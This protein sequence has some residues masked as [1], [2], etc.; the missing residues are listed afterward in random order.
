MRHLLLSLLI[1]APVGITST[2]VVQ[3]N[4]PT[5]RLTTDSYM[6]AYPRWLPWTSPI[7]TMSVYPNP[8]NPEV[9]PDASVI[10]MALDSKGNAHIVYLRPEVGEQ[11]WP[12]WYQNTI[13]QTRQA[14]GFS[15][16][17]QITPTQTGGNQ[18]CVAVAGN[19]DVYVAWS[20]GSTIYYRR[21]DANGWG[22]PTDLDPSIPPGTSYGGPKMKTAPDGTVHL[23]AFRG[24]TV[25]YEG[26]QK[27]VRD[28]VHAVPGVSFSTLTQASFNPNPPGYYPEYFKFAFGPG[29]QLVLVWMEV[30]TDLGMPPNWNPAITYYATDWGGKVPMPNPPDVEPDLAVDSLGNCHMAWRLTTSAEWMYKSTVSDVPVAIAGTGN[31]AFF[32]RGG[33]VV[34]SRDQV[35]LVYS[36]E[37]QG[38]FS[39]SRLKNPDPQVLNTVWRTQHL[40]LPADAKRRQNTVTAPEPVW[41][42]LSPN[43]DGDV[44]M[45]KNDQLHIR[46]GKLYT[47]T[48][49]YGTGVQDG[50]TLVGACPGGT[51]NAA[52]GNLNIRIPLF[53][54]KGVGPTQNLELRYNSLDPSVGSIAP[55]WKF[56]YEMYLI[57]PFRYVNKPGAPKGYAGVPEYPAEA[58]T[59]FMP[60]GRP[61]VFRFH[62]FYLTDNSWGLLLP[63]DEFGDFSSLSR[64]VYNSMTTEYTLTT[65]FGDKYVFNTAGKLRSILD[66]DQNRIDLIYNASGQLTQIIDMLGNGGVGRT[67]TITYEPQT[68]QV[69]PPRP[70]LITDPAAK[71]YE[72]QYT[73]NFLTGVRFLGHATQPT[74]TMQYSLDNNVVTKERVNQLRE[75]RT[76]RGNAW[77]CKYLP[78]GRVCEIEDPPAPYLLEG[79]ADGSVPG[80]HVAKIA[81]TYDETLPIPGPRETMLVDR[82]GFQTKYKIDGRRFLA[83]EIHDQAYLSG[84]PGIFPVI[85][86]F[87]NVGNVTDLQDR[88]G[89]HTLY[90]YSNDSG[91]THKDNLLTVRRPLP[92]GS[93][94][95]LVAEYTY[96]A[97]YNRPLT[98]TTYATPA[99]GGPVQTRTTTYTHEFGRLLSIF[100]PSV[101]RPDG[102]VQAANTQFTYNS[103][104]RY[105]MVIHRNEELWTTTFSNLDPVHGLPR[106]V[107][108]DGGTQTQEITYDAMGN[109]LQHK[110]PQGGSGNDLPGWTIINRD[111]LYR[112]SSVTD[113]KGKITTYD[114]DLDSN[115][116]FVIPPVGNQTSYTYDARGFASGGTGPDGTWAQWVDAAGNLRRSRDLRGFESNSTL[117]FM[118]RTTESRVPGGTTT[119]GGGGGPTSHV[120]QYAYDQLDTER[121]STVTQVGIPQNRVTRTTYDNRGRAKSILEPDGLTRTDIIFDEQDQ[122]I[123]SQQFYNSVF[124]RCTVTFRDA[125]DR[126]DRT[127]DQDV[128]YGTALVNQSNRYTLYNRVGSVVRTVDPLG[129]VTTPATN[130]HKTTYVLDARERVSQVIDGKGVTVRQNVWGDDDQLLE[131]WVPDPENKTSSLVLSQSMTYTERKETKASRD[132]NNQGTTYTYGDLR[133]QQTLATDALSRITRMDYDAAT[134]RILRLIESEGTPDENRTEYTHSAGFLTQTKVFNPESG[135]INSI[136]QRTYDKAGRLEK[137]EAPQVTAE[138]FFFNDFSEASQ[139]IRGS[140]SVAKLY[141]SIGQLTTATWSGVPGQQTY[142]YNG[143]GQTASVTD[144][145]RKIDYSYDVW[146]GT[147]KDETLSVGGSTWK[148]QTHQFD[149][150]GNNTGLTDAEAQ[151]HTW[152]VD[153]NNRVTERKLGANSVMSITYTPAG[154]VDK[155]ILKNAAGATIATTI[156]LYDGL[157]RKTGMQ[158]V[159]AGTNEVLSNLSLGYDVANQVTGSNVNHLGVVFTIGVDG[160][161]QLK[162]QTTPGNN[163][164]TI[165]PPPFTQPPFGPIG[166]GME[167]A[168]SAEAQ[169]R[170]R[171]MLPVPARSAS[172]VYS[173][174]GLRTSQT[175]DGV[176][177]TYAYNSAG[178]LITESS[179]GKTVTHQYDEWGNESVRTTTGTGAKTET[180][181]YNH[182]NRLSSYTNT[183]TGANWQYDFWPDG[184]RYGK[185]NVAT[186]T[187]EL[188]VNRFGDVVN[189]YSKIGAGTATLQNSYVQGTGIDSKNTRITAGG[190]R[191]HFTTNQVGTLGMTLDDAGAAVDTVVKDGWGNG[192]AGST[193]ERFGGLAQRE[194]DS[195]S[196]LLY[197]RN[198]MY[199]PL[200]GRFTQTDPIM[201]RRPFA[202]YAYAANN[203]VSMIDPMGLQEQEGQENIEE[204]QRR[205]AL[206]RKPGDVKKRVIAVVQ[207]EFPRTSGAIEGLAVGKANV[208]EAY[209][210][211]ASGTAYMVCHPISTFEAAKHKTDQTVTAIQENGFWNTMGDAGGGLWTIA[212]DNPS[213]FAANSSATAATLL[214]PTKIPGLGSTRIGQALNTE[215]KCLSFLDNSVGEVAGTALGYAKGGKSAAGLEGGTSAFGTHS[216]GAAEA[217]PRYHS[218][219]SDGRLIVEGSQPPRIQG[220]QSLEPHSVLRWDRT[221][222][223]VYQAREYGLDGAPVRDIDFTNP[224]YPNG[225]PRP[226]HAGPPHQHRWTISN[227]N[228]G[229]KSGYTRGDPVPLQ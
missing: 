160:R 58:I 94:H 203:P 211:V 72:L 96:T 93:G 10:S 35:H 144:G 118:G 162:T 210:N 185:T 174:A 173:P 18:P 71:Q 12:V 126:V 152:L 39:S 114:Y 188:Y 127:R 62:P 111:G 184:N 166:T 134:Q 103:S 119:T 193:S 80:T 25:T 98:A 112:L 216:A 45:S 42:F 101:T 213:K 138:Q 171:I 29:G 151:S 208:D 1:V 202:H 113:P 110:A 56:N 82:R 85:R 214:I 206:F 105:A 161:G 153:E 81:L 67:S 225:T 133:G 109:V 13:F 143:A 37:E 155:E 141:N 154:L 227:P 41:P 88:W 21:K 190:L 75:F 207:S 76:P 89:Q 106:T 157:G 123:A 33:L 212:K 47:R 3:S 159:Q 124:Q 100:H 70:V 145:P 195:E 5:E 117:D 158:T 79:E 218:V 222:K 60:D 201:G 49:E 26:Q 204:L 163:G 36:T 221:N 57:D 198:R 129:V 43:L 168:P 180:F 132:R 116:T 120:T 8:W 224:T 217:S 2:R 128:P 68:S 115:Q 169:A 140:R 199:D 86:T 164:G 23:V 149:N 167:S 108:R 186:N 77:I 64:S 176:T 137:L 22:P 125:R 87:D 24:Y 51:V 219:Y 135:L 102:T 27:A 78:D 226:G 34:D 30:P 7:S 191:R 90:T 130:A 50:A 192:I 156:H 61:I 53:G 91:T 92:S 181:L 20:S 6:N 189:E 44:L 122:V 187:S 73:G 95:E 146:R 19:G 83:M 139:V 229:P 170:P 205:Q 209:T 136:H 200:I 177:T 165:T 121:F 215:L 148:L 107:A 9:T 32:S 178:Q 69:V 11:Y 74:F 55:G 197:V 84:T 99:G 228:V 172:Y 4:P 131:V 179:P 147:V 220:P 97:F 48:L 196:G 14:N 54:T 182:L 150:A 63:E 38:Y 59:V 65:K 52:S 142:T 66:P 183:L 223:R 16:R 28:L 46:T 194:I 175:I 104:L 15:A 40:A 31:T 17:E